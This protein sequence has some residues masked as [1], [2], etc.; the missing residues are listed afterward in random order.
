MSGQVLSSRPD[1]VP[2]EYVE[3][4]S[5]VQDSLPPWPMED[6]RKFLVQSLQSELRIVEDLDDVFDYI[7]PNALGSASIGQVHAAVISEHWASWRDAPATSTTSTTRRLDSGGWNNNN[8]RNVAIKV[9]HPGA[10]ECFQHDFQVFRWLCRLALPS[11]MGLLDELERR[12]MTEF[13]YRNEADMLRLVR[14][15]MERSPYR[16]RVHVPFPH[17]TLCTQHV[18]VMEL[19]QGQKLVDDVKDKLDTALGEPGVAAKL[20]RQR[21]H[22]VASGGAV[23]TSP[24][25][26]QQMLPG[27]DSMSLLTKL[28]LL[29]IQKRC[30]RYVDLLVDV[31]GHQ[32]FVDGAFNA[33]PHP[34][35]VLVLNDGRLG[36]IDY[37]QTRQLSDAERLAYAGVVVS[38]GEEGSDAVKVAERFRDC[39]FV[40]RHP[41][42][43]DTLAQY[44]ALFFDT[45]RESRDRGFATPQLY[46]A[47]LMRTNPL[48]VI[49]DAA[50]TSRAKLCQSC[51]CC[52]DE[53]LPVSHC[54][55][56]LLR[57]FF[58]SIH[59]PDEFFVS[60]D[61]GS[62]R[63]GIRRP[64]CNPL[65]K[66]RANCLGPSGC[67]R[68][69]FREGVGGR[70]NS[71]LGGERA[72]GNAAM[73]S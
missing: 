5:T 2:V 12:I 33:D 69:C 43:S 31:H 72:A 3:L 54:S 7:N 16:R 14:S 20:L 51:C 15:N 21:Q 36:L 55:P 71:Y 34:G 60:R 38:L 25:D 70:G 57:F 27:L 37:G 24:T 19:L 65:G 58:N 18:L 73:P 45:D 48:L 52:C 23:P 17:P 26:G 46:Y 53:G 6:V 28:R 30:Q 47:S 50:G 67:G 13:D 41:G 4:F 35:N 66:A 22:Q 39:G 62:R 63:I 61:G 9:M 10:K 56:P 64:H 49:P 68:L 8:N 1:F 29:A 32:I 59:C 42:D 40:P 11:W 44:A